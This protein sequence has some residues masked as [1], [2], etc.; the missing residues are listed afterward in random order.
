MRLSARMLQWCIL[1]A[2][3]NAPCPAADPPDKNAL[4]AARVR[5][6]MEEMLHRL[7]D[8]TCV[9]TIE[10]SARSPSE[11]KFRLL[12][13]TRV[14]VAYVKGK[15]LFAW[16]GAPRF[17]ERNLA[18]MVGGTGAIGTGDFALHLM[19]AYRG[20]AAL[21][22]VG[23][24]TLAGRATLKFIQNVPIELSNFKVIVPPATG[25]VG[26]QVTAWHDARSLAL[27]RFELLVTEFPLG[28][29]IRRAF[30]AIEY[31]DVKVGET[32]FRL[33]AVTEL[34]MLHESG[35]ESRTVSTFSQCRQYL[36]ESKITFGDVAPEGAE[37]TV[38]GSASLPAG[39]SVPVKLS[40][41][42]ELIAAARGDMVE[43]A[44]SRAVVHDGRTLL[45]RGTK[46]AARI[47]K[48]TCET[49]PYP[50]CFVE[51]RTETYEDASR[52]GPF[53]SLLEAPTLESLLAQRRVVTSGQGP[54][55]I[56]SEFAHA[57]SDAPIL[58]VGP[59]TRLPRGYQMIWRTLEVP[60]GVTP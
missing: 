51:L 54:V 20:N 53:T 2:A 24:D 28:I 3:V 42:I 60:G 26:Y 6:S 39:V 47:D 49:A 30:K 50:N 29:P 41:E 14:E 40:R 8:Y 55:L 5:A 57:G 33:P 52:S 59:G 36:G 12:D 13:R 4:L 43:M 25:V 38:R 22:F 19:A 34:S 18:E 46:I 16:P 11:K 1:A 56:P 37:T 45:A 15:E 17:E 7:P 21:E 32:A 35:V 31:Q 23:N 48:V 10:R 58:F 9:E 44:V 27:Q